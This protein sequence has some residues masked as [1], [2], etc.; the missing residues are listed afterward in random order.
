MTRLRTLR[1]G[2]THNAVDIRFVDNPRAGSQH[3][4]GYTQPYYTF[5]D[6]YRRQ[7]TNIRKLPLPRVQELLA[8]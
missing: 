1:L 3:L 4:L 2:H 7:A 6:R 5:A 8:A